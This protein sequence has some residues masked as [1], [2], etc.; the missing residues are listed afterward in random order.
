MIL[1]RCLLEGFVISSFLV[2][3]ISYFRREPFRSQRID[4][5]LLKAGQPLVSSGCFCHSWVI[6]L[7][8]GGGGTTVS[9]CV[10]TELTASAWIKKSSAASL[11]LNVQLK[12]LCSKD[13]TRVSSMWGQAGELTWQTGS[14]TCVWRQTGG[15]SAGRWEK[16]N[17]GS[18]LSLLNNKVFFS[19]EK[20]KD[21]VR[22]CKGLFNLIVL[23]E[24]LYAIFHLI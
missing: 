11:L 2:L 18:L 14:K 23:T 3:T 10:C 15:S 4:K 22:T 21:Y 17:P 9:V 7:T 16:A 5:R 19:S 24:F 20:I 6:L 8:A 1:N 12:C 13:N